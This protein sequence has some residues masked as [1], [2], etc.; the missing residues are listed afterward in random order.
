MENKKRM[1]VNLVASLVAFATNLFIGM[2]LT[3]YISSTLGDGAYGFIGIANNFVSYA[4]I[5]TIALNSMASRFIAIEIHKKNIKK[6]NIYFN[7][8]IIAN[9]IMALVLVIVSIIMIVNLEHIL[10]ISDGLVMDVKI[11]FAIVFANFIISLMSSIYSIAPFVKNRI[12]LTSIRNIIGHL[13]RMLVLVPLFM[14][15]PPK[16]YYVG[17]SAMAMTIFLAIASVT[18]SK[19]LMPEIKVNL[20]NFSYKAIKELLSSGVWNSLNQLSTVLLTGLEL[21]IA[22]IFISEAEAGMLSIAKTVPGN[23][24]ALLGTLGGVFTPQFIKT[25]AENRIDDLVGQVKF[26]MKVMTLIMSVPLA[27]FLIF[28][29]SFYSVWLPYKSQEEIIKIQILSVL[30]ILPNVFSS[31]IYTLYSINTVTNKLKVP[32]MVTFILSIIS[33]ITV[34]LLLKYTTLGV[35]AVAGVSS[36]ILVLRIVF[37]V[38]TYAAYNLGIKWTTFYPMLIR[39]LGCFAILCGI[40]YVVD[41]LVTISSWGDLFIVAFCCGAIGYIINLVTVL[42]SKERKKVICMVRGKIR[43]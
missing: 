8:V 9:T 27:G 39:G 6:A 32:V 37:F 42:N 12:D 10:R 15:L 29:T 16:I 1:S 33:I 41:S 7:S 40:F 25:Y 20:K 14:L 19:R 21:V 36:I 38:P 34:F 35:Y 17:I 4:N 26:S 11:T 3:P 18:L 2:V 30:T 5:L 23:I 22:N 13:I 43:K 28:G 31:Y 24:I